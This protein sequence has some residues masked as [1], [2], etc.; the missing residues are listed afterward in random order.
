M[1]V[2][3]LTGGIGSGKSSILN[4]FKEKGIPAFNADQEAKKLMQED[5]KLLNK[6]RQLFGD[7][8]F[9]FG[10]L[11]RNRLA[12]IVFSDPSKLAK[13]NALIHPEVATRFQRFKK[14][15]TTPYLI[16][17][18]AILFE[19]G[20]WKNCDQTILVCAPLEQRIERVI[21][22]DN[23]T[24]EV[25]ISRI[26]NQWSDEKKIPLADFVIHNEN[27]NKTLLEINAIHLALL[28]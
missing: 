7:N 14:A 20:G 5:T 25:V 15:H 21:Q 2:I 11:D 16:K 13:L 4:V 17:E 1:K 24:R 3:G 22:R 10:K 27:W 23:C 8:I 19:T 6:L 28:Q 9:E 18:A 26:N 12:T